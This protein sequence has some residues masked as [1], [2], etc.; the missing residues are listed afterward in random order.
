MK[1]NWRVDIFIIGVNFLDS[2]PVN[3]QLTIIVIVMQTQA[4][5]CFCFTNI[6][7]NLFLC[8]STAAINIINQ[9]FT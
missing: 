2:F 3:K 7:N 1:L 9:S 5:L 8:C 4:K 6:N